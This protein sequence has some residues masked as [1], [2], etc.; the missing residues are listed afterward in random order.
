MQLLL[1]L[2]F[3]AEKGIKAP[4]GLGAE[5]GGDGKAVIDD[6]VGA[7]RS[8]KAFALRPRPKQA[9]APTKGS[10]GAMAN[11]ALQMF[12][13][14]KAK[15]AGNVIAESEPRRGKDGAKRKPK[16]R[17]ASSKKTG[18]ASS[19]KTGESSKKRESTKKAED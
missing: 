8:G 5:G 16:S 6:L 13:R 11:E 9:A 14:L 1:I 4:A 10:G 17:E 2:T 19:K 15:R 12:A 18:E 7:L 3:K